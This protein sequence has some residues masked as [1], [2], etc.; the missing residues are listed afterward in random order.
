MRAYP[1]FPWPGTA[2]IR[3]SIVVWFRGQYKGNCYINNQEVK[4]ISSFLDS[5]LV[6]NEPKALKSNSGFSYKGVDTGG[7]GFVVTEE[8]KNLLC[9]IDSQTEK[10]IWPFINGSD[11]LSH[12]E[13][14]ASRLIINLSNMKLEDVKHYD[15]VYKFILERVKPYRD[16]VKRDRNKAYWW[17][18][19]EPRPGLYNSISNLSRVLVNCVVSKYIC[20][21]F[22]PVK[23][24]FSNALNIFASDFLY[25]FPFCKALYTN[26]GQDIMLQRL[27]LIL[28]TIQQTVLKRSHFQIG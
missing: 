8:E 5:T 6:E 21:D 17:I 12:P 10:L 14:K 13:Q 26:S 2:S 7:L 3:I 28:D 18:Y 19:N 20:F 4:V 22:L 1:D 27:E 11:F 16:T 9:K 25:G 24:V 15:T 23:M